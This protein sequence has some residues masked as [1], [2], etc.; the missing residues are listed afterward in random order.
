METVGGRQ[1]LS[2]EGLGKRP[3]HQGE[4]PVI[5]DDTILRL[6]KADKEVN[7]WI[8]LPSR[9]FLVGTKGIA[10]TQLHSTGNSFPLPVGR[11][12]EER[13]RHTTEIQACGETTISSLP[14]RVPCSS[15][16]DANIL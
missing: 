8:L 12:Q 10:C 13:K 3:C 16:L 6:L 2:L 14:P 15:P 9:P 11:L 7:L 5:R 4:R 1:E